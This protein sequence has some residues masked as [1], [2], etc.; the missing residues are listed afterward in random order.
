MND[1]RGRQAGFNALSRGQWENF[2]GH[3][4]KVLKLLATG[5]GRLCVLGAGNGNDLD[6]KALLDVYRETHLVDLDAKAL[7]LGA[8]RQ[9][10]IDR[11]GLF[12][13]GGL[14]VTGMVAVM[15]RWNP[16]SEIG[17]V[18]LE[19]LAS[20]PTG[21]VAPALPGPFDVVASTCLLSPLIGN[22]FHSIGEAHPRF[23]DVVKALRVGH[24]RLLTGLVAPG[25]TAL[26]ITDVVSSDTLPALRTMPESALPGLIPDVSRRGNV[27]H[28]VNPAELVRQ[29]RHDPVLKR[30]VAG[31]ETLGPWRWNLHDR[32][33]LVIA[34]RYRVNAV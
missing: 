19:A 7:D 20:A 12:R 18:E 34:Y 28:G 11:A 32:V 6:M 23:L 4:Q 10:V 2:S 13:Y 33:Y 9:G 5:R 17:P 30:S 25:G 27:F 31:L 15:A 14:D 22:A 1:I 21:R 24:L 8:G 16:R 26:L 29:F 3:R